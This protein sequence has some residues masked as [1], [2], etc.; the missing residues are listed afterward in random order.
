METDSIRRL[1]KIAVGLGDLRGRVVF[2]GGC[3][4]GLYATDSAAFGSLLGRSN[5]R[6]E[7]ECALPY[8]ESQR[9]D[10]I[11]NLLKKIASRYIIL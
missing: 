9:V 11:I 1:R 5:I 3:V 8:G 7:I 4:A 2:V 10:V 6:E